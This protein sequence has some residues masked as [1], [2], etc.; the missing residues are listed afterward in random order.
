MALPFVDRADAGRQLAARLQ[1]LKDADPLVLAVP[2]GGVPVGF[3]I[4]KALGATLD[5]ILVRKI[6]APFQPELALG[7][8]VDG[9]HAETVL[10]E[11]IVASLD[12][13]EDFLKTETARQLAEI[14]RRR[15]AYLGDRPQPPIAGRSAIVVDDGIATGATIRAALRAVR[16]NR[17]KRLVLA[18]P[19]APP[20]TV[21]RLRPDADELVCLETPEAFF[22]I[23]QFYL[24][25][26]QLADGDVIDILRRAR[27][28]VGHE[29]GASSS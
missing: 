27:D 10:N 11:E 13:P 18:T 20:D 6:G 2:R 4:A 14:E 12:L 1:H 23:G 9:D 28:G 21:E 29:T 3:E 24:D 15:K 25:F 7:A 22:A 5:L 16:R 26:T 19:V 8:V 17:P